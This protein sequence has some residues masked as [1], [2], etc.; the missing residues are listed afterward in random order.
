MSRK[1]KPKRKVGNYKIWFLNGTFYLIGYCHVRD[2][3]IIFAL[4]RIKI[5]HQTD[6]TFDILKD[7]TLEEFIGASFGVFRG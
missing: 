5:L 4:D 7:F 3:I 1:E 6:D 2:E